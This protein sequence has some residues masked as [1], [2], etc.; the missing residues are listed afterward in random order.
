MIHRSFKETL[1]ADVSDVFL[2]IAEFGEEHIVDG[3]AIVIVF[4]DVEKIAREKGRVVTSD[5]IDGIFR[6]R[7]LFYASADDFSGLPRVGRL[8]ILDGKDY[9]VAEAAEEGG[10]YVITLEANDN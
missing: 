9:R 2:N 6:N 1:K 4:D 3:K 10:V 5:Y 7:K 8:M